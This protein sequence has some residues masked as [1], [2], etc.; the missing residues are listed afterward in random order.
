M[1]AELT[2]P[3]L[4]DSV[5]DAV[6][7][8]WLKAPGEGFKRGDALME[9]E[10]DKATVVYEAEDDGRLESIL[11]QE[12]E[13][14]AVGQAIAK[15]SGTAGASPSTGRRRRSGR[16][17]PPLCRVVPTPHRSRAAPP[18]SSAFPSTTSPAPAPAG[19]SPARTCSA[20]T[21]AAASRAGAATSASSS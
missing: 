9:V 13:A 1:A 14:A 5:A 10:T 18:S 21:P 16:T 20:L 19:G 11:V 8:R 3:K 4:S 2:M 12:G 7:L 6:I 15:L 17:A